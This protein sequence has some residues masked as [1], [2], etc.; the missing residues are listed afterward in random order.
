MNIDEDELIEMM[1]NYWAI[2]NNKECWEK[3][4][5]FCKKY[6]LLSEVNINDFYVE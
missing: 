2:V 3:T 5:K 1:N 4:L 6:G